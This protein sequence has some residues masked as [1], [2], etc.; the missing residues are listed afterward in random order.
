MKEVYKKV[1]A[2][3]TRYRKNDRTTK[4]PQLPIDCFIDQTR[5]I[6]DIDD[7]F[8]TPQGFV[9]RFVD[10]LRNAHQYYLDRIPRWYMQPHYVE[11]WL[12]KNAMRQTF[13]SILWKA[14]QVRIV[15][16]NGWSSLTYINDNIARL[17][18]IRAT[19]SYIKHIHILYFGDHDPSGWGM[20]AKIIRDLDK[21][22]GKGVIDFK[23]VGILK[24]HIKEFGLHDL[25]NP[26]P[27]VLAK[28]RD[29]PDRFKFMKE[30]NGELFQ[31]EFD[32]MQARGAA[33]LKKLLKS[34]SYNDFSE[35]CNKAYITT[36]KYKIKNI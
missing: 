11:V 5:T 27:K 31:I 23:R 28:L 18:E 6:S 36:N 32:A 8:I 2:A 20:D 34:L 7:E 26:D 9:D 1:D 13:K 3:F 14:R 25:K 19:H 15:P 16:N 22:F 21:A 17:R 29:D 12:E 33:K 35:L 30:N 24:E 4:E 10:V